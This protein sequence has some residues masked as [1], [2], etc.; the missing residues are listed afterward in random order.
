[1]WDGTIQ[2]Q[3]I[4]SSIV[5]SIHPSRV[6]WD[7]RRRRAGRRPAHFNPPI[8]CGMGPDCIA[9][10]AL[11]FPHFNPPIP[12]GMGQSSASR[13]RPSRLF[14][15]THPVWDGTY[16]L[17][18]NIQS[19]A[20]FNP[21]IPCGMG[22]LKYGK[23]VPVSAISIHPSRVGWDPAHQVIPDDARDFNPPIP[24]G[25]GPVKCFGLELPGLIS[26]HPSR[27]GWDA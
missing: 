14:Q 2:G 19:T 27:V 11:D 20:D 15:S 16:N 6:G 1:M 26:I 21:P 3:R 23:G 22:H 18:G 25:M 10:C 12:C 4:S 17:F 24:C 8:P 5:I 13:A 9:Y 7:Q